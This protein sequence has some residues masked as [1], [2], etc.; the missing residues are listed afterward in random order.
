MASFCR[1]NGFLSLRRSVQRGEIQI[2]RRDDGEPDTFV[3]HSRFQQITAVD[4]AVEAAPDAV[5][6]QDLH[7]SRHTKEPN[8]GGK[9]RYTRISSEEVRS[10][11]ASVMHSSSRSASR[12]T[13]LP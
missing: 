2:I 10:F 5:G 9:C 1:E 8:T 6:V 12:L 13:S 11:S 3:F 4:V 7:E